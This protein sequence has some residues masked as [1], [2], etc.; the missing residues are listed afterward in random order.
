[1][2]NSLWSL[3]Q[4]TLQTILDPVFVVAAMLDVFNVRRVIIADLLGSVHSNLAASYII[5]LFE[6]LVY[7][8]SDLGV[9]LDFN[10]KF[11][12]ASCCNFL[13]FIVDINVDIF[14]HL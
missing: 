13:T 3:D 6:K 14:L 7:V 1:M 9:L 11:M 5:F 10:S 8:F 2:K 4:L 12:N